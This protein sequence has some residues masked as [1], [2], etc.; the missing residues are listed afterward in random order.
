[1]RS[2]HG[3]RVASRSM[4]SRRRGHQHHRGSRPPPPPATLLPLATPGPPPTPA[5][6]TRTH[7]A[8]SKT[9]ATNDDIKRSE[10]VDSATA[11]AGGKLGPREAPDGEE[12]RPGSGSDSD[13]ETAELA[14]LR[15]ASTCT[16]LVAERENRR[17]RRCADYPGLAFGSSIF[18][19]DTMMKFSII[20]NELQNI[21]NTALKRV[22]SYFI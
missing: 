18:S 3:G 13:P 12:A 15:C 10:K 16:E 11:S 14:S 8:L 21:K 17:R 2:Q 6:P 4:S 1:M 5:K 9:D 22:M 20:K 19:S 7:S